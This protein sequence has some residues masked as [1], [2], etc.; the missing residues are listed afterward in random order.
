MGLNRQGVQRIAD[1]LEA[2]GL[3][4]F[5]PNPRHARAQLVML[6]RKGRAACA[7][8]DA[9]QI[10]WVNALAKGLGADEISAATRTA[11]ELRRRLE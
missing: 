7:T 8:A 11:A 5:R 6:T 4:E 9:L 3:L 10:S 2:E 1:E